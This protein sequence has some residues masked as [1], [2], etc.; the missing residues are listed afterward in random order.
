M[1][2]QQVFDVGRIILHQYPSDFRRRQKLLQLVR[3]MGI[4]LA[5][6]L[7]IADVRADGVNA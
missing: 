6:H 1:S 2:I 5:R 3:D 4:T 7:L